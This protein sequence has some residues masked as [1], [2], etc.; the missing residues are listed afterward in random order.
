MK[1]KLK[2]SLS[3]QLKDNI[4]AEV[5]ETYAKQALR[6][7]TI[8]Y[9]EIQADP[10]TISEEFLEKDLTMLAIAGIKD[11]IRPEIQQAV[12]QCKEAGITVRM[13]TGDNITTA[14]AIARDCGIIDKDEVILENSYIAMEGKKFRELVGGIIWEFPNEKD[15]SK[16][17][18]SGV[19]NKEEFKRIATTTRVLARSTPDDKYLLVTGLIELDNVIA[20]TGD[21]TNDAPALKKADVGFAMGIA[22]T[23]VAKEAASIILLDDNFRSIVT[24]CKWGRNIY[25][26]IRKFIQFQLTINIVALFMAFLGAVVLSHSPI[27]TIQLLWVNLIMDTFAALALATEPPNDELLKRQ[28][29][30]RKE[31]IITPNMWRNILGQSLF[32][33]IVLTIFLFLGPSI[34]GIPNTAKHSEGKYIPKYYVHFTMFFNM[35]VFIQ[36]FNSINCRKLKRDEFNMFKDF[37]NN[38]LFFVINLITVVFQILIVEFGGKFVKTTHLTVTQHLICIAIGSL[39]LIVSVLI[40]LIP[41]KVF[42]GIKLLREP[43]QESIV[44]SSRLK[45]RGTIQLQTRFLKTQ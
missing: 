28:P 18:K 33:I 4:T 26:C 42:K 14:I 2:F 6:T 1:L 15:I 29:Y 23:D 3:S 10:N 27:N 20:V 32:Q 43:P 22:G 8:A 35:F 34:M 19:R 21:G 41:V 24:A 45:K 31:S 25:D 38:P 30:G 12:V 37:F 9:K 36:I 44:T 5:I 17:G 7:I 13:V 40:K 16:R 39:S 11:P